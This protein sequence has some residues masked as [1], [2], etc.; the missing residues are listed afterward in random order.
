MKL[1]GPDNFHNITIKFKTKILFILLLTVEL[2]I[3]KAATGA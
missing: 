1:F 2:L 3:A